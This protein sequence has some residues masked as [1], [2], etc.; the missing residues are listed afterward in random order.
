[1]K[2]INKVFILLSLIMLIIFSGGL[3][4]ACSNNSY[5]EGSYETVDG[6][7][8][9]TANVLTKNN[10]T[11]HMENKVETSK[12]VIDEIFATI[13]TDYNTLQSV[14]NRKTKIK[15][16]IIE[17][18]YI[19]G[20]NHGAYINGNIICNI[21]VIN[22]GSYKLF[23]T[24]A[25]LN[26]TETWKQY[27]ACQYAFSFSDIEDIDFK[28]YYAD[29]ANL[30]S[31]TLF[32][33]YFNE[34]FSDKDTISIAKQTAY[35]FGN[36]VLTNYDLKKF[37]AAD[38]LQYRQE[39]LDS[40]QCN[41]CFDIPYDLSWLDGAQYSQKLFQYPIVITTSNRTYYL[42]NFYNARPTAS[43]DTAERVLCH[44]SQGY[45]ESLK[46]LEHIR[47]NA[48]KN[49]SSVSK[50]FKSKIEYFISDRELRTQCDMDRSTIYLLDPS[51]YIHETIHIISLSENPTDAAWLC[52]GI[53]EY[54][55]RSV[56]TQLADI[57][58]RFYES[59]SLT[60]LSGKLK[61][62]VDAVNAKYINMGGNYSD[63]E[64]FDFAILEE[65]I[66]IT[67]LTFPQY[68]S[69]ITFPY[70]T[71]S[72]YYTYSKASYT[73]ENKLTYPEA[74]AFTK[75]LID[76]YGLD[77]VLQCCSSY[78]FE[79]IFGKSFNDVFS[80]FYAEISISE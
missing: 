49:Y 66:G 18:T 23:L 12:E 29:N 54:F 31:L 47:I 51:E 13:E 24:A 45:S 60:N 38:L 73:D 71:N 67:T 5:V 80:K 44:L 16:Y 59:F 74:F 42:D 61:E 6:Y 65:A 53:A 2:R 8:N 14:W 21:D 55:A 30:L 79:K 50:K 7:G 3:L 63:I 10:I 41:Q 20:V 56:S 70:A 39:W 62:F 40:I 35:S 76:T 48:P 19:L 17:D 32:T 15:I 37:L 11:L 52:E 58:Y 57:N 25:Y 46:I 77:K 26:T 33:A 69:Q 72:I 75:Y 28:D 36:F 78:N 4:S 68:K 43:F 27:A 34:N 22:D 9:I 1:M 64:T